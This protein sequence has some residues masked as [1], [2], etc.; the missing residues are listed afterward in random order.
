MLVFGEGGEGDIDLGGVEARREGQ[1]LTEEINFSELV[2]LYTR[3][4]SK[5]CRETEISKGVLCS[6]PKESRLRN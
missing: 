4:V 1:N 2:F 5:I 6:S 3:S